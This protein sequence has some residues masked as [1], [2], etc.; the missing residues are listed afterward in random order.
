VT[1][2][3]NGANGYLSGCLWAGNVGWIKVGAGNGPYANTTA[4]NYGGNMDA[5][6]NLSGYAWS[7]TVG[8]INF[9]PTHGGVSINTADGRFDG[10]AW[11]ENIGWIHFKNAAP[12]YNVRT[13]VFDVLPSA[14]SGTGFKFK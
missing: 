12:A 8:W 1:V 13:T 6:G 10:Y 11:A 9:S 2:V 7:E 4:S 3:T 5:A 14:W